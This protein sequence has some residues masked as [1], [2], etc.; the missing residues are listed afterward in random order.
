MIALA[1]CGCYNKTGLRPGLYLPE[2]LFVSKGI[3]FI[4]P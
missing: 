3:D 2:A 4:N 1:A